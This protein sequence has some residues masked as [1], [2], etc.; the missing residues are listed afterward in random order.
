MSTQESLSP[1][2]NL[3]TNDYIVYRLRDEKVHQGVKR[4]IILDNVDQRLIILLTTRD[5][6]TD[7]D[8]ETHVV[9]ELYTKTNFNLDIDGKVEASY[10]KIYLE[11]LKRPPQSEKRS[12]YNQTG[13]ESTI[14]IAILEGIMKKLNPVK[15]RIKGKSTSSSQQQPT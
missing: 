13:I 15:E 9:I 2:S 1:Y 14:L 11:Y 3:I 10:L 4:S 7:T 8:D 5:I 6:E 12:F